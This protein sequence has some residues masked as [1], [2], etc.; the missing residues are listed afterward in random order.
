MEL[1]QGLA[2]SITTLRA[3]RQFTVASE[4]EEALQRFDTADVLVAYLTTTGGDLDKKDRIY[5]ALVRA[6]QVQAEW[7]ELAT[8]LL[9][10][11]LWPGLDAIHG[12][13]L[14][15]FMGRPDELVAEISFIFT[16]TVSR[17]DLGGVNRL[18]A[19]LVL[20][21]ERDVR[22]ALK[23]RWADEARVLD[24]DDRA[25]TGLHEHLET[26][27]TVD[28][29]ELPVDADDLLA[30]RTWLVDT[31]HGDADLVIGAVLYGFDLH[32]F[33][34]MLGIGHEAAR[35]RFQ[36]AIKRIRERLAESR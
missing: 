18:A 12:R 2:R 1:R 10:L 19:T 23:R 13:R 24:V 30:V 8:A 22:G 3:D 26:R 17:I 4:A 14:R 9:W 6:V 31:V 15:D 32:E 35:K 21:V 7:R 34:D 33:A 5:L 25:A 16:T 20:N 28:E 36:R 27:P 11:G 29:R